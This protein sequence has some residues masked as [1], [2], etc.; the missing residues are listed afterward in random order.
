MVERL[1]AR[2]DAVGWD[3]T[4]I[5]LDD[6]GALMAFR[7]RDA[8]GGA[9]LGRRH[10]IAM[11]AGSVARASRRPTSRFAP[12]RRWRSPRTGIDYPVALRVRAGDVELRS[13]R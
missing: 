5:N 13:S 2:A 11:R 8:H 4:G 1:P 9:T 10:A 6:G 12:L 3:W 7:I